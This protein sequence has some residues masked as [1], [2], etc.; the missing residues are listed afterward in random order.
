MKI[1]KFKEWWWVFLC[2][3]FL[4]FFYCFAIEGKRKELSSLAYELTKKEK[5]KEMALMEKE[6]LELQI[7]SQDDPSWIEMLLIRDLGV[8]P[9]GWL[10]VHFS[11][12][13]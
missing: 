2:Q 7:N 10:K 3:L 1:G 8:V 13:K 4:F 5:E 12:S 11:S 6:D 9:E